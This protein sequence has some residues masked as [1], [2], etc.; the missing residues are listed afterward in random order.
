[1][2]VTYVVLRGNGVVVVRVQEGNLA[3]DVAVEPGDIAEEE[4]DEGAGGDT[5]A[6]SNGTTKRKSVCNVWA[7]PLR[8]P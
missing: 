2:G 8:G 5:E 6:T 3:D 1:M 4:H 7:R